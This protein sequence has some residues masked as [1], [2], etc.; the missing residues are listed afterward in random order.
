MFILGVLNLTVTQGM[1]NGLIFY[2]NIIWTYKDIFFEQQ[3]MS[4][5]VTTFLKVFI[6]WINLDFGIETCFVEGLTAFWKTWLH[7]VFPF[8]I[9]TISG[10]IIAIAKSSS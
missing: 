7:F 4:N 5:I 6:T 3:E 10:L 2:A 9:W 8:Y 1:I